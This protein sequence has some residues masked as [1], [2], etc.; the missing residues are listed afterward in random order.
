MCGYAAIPEDRCTYRIYCLEVNS[1]LHLVQLWQCCSEWPLFADMFQICKVLSAH[2]DIGVT[3]VN[4]QSR[5]VMTS[6]HCCSM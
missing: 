5:V 4:H 2:V 1:R 6:V 3:A